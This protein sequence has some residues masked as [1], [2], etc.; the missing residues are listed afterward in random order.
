MIFFNEASLTSPGVA[1]LI[2]GFF[3]LS[4]DM[5]LAV[6]GMLNPKS[7]SL[8]HTYELCHEHNWFTVYLQ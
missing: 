8:L 4:D 7:T 3:S 6:V 1:G 5:T 2:L